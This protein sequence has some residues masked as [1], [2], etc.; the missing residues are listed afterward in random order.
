MVFAAASMKES[1]EAVARQFEAASG[2]K[3]VISFGASSSLARQ[4]E[5]GAPAHLFVSADT[6]WLDYLDGK[7]QLAPGTR[8]NLLKNQL[9]LIAPAESRASIKLGPGVNLASALGDRP[10]A[11]AN[12]DVVPAGKYGKAALQSLGAWQTVA[13]K[14]ARA[15]NVRAALALVSRGEASLGIVYRTDALADKGVRIVD[16]FPASSHAPIIFPAALTAGTKSSAASAMLA[17]LA[18][19]GAKPVWQRFG[20]EPL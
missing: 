19:A 1:L 12:P 6:D 10:L 18:S 11:M 16:T 7:R 2:H 15:E 4:I 8:I 20:F 9:V 17:H 14:T 3:V 13:N 5:A